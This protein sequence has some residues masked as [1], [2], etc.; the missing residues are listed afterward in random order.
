MPPVRPWQVEPGNVLEKWED[1]LWCV[2]GR[3]PGNPALPRRMA[4]V[5][6]GDGRLLFYNGI[7]VD[8]PTLAEI[9]AFGEPTWLLI[10]HAYHMI[11]GPAFQQKLGLTNRA[12]LVRYAIDR[13]LVD[14]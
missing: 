12:E 3:V 8:D 2:S 14:I 1:N 9:R 5:R 6:L 11:D 10:P 7:P 4:V 13:G